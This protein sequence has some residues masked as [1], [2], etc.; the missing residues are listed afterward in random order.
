[1]FARKPLLSWIFAGFVGLSA[2]MP[3]AY[4]ALWPPNATPRTL[5]ELTLLLSEA[6]P[7]LHVI[8]V[9]PN[10]PENGV[11]VCE[12]PRSWEQLSWLRRAPEYSDQWQGV[13]YCERLR[14]HWYILEEDFDS[15]G[16]NALRVGP[17]LF[18]GD[19]ALLRRIHNA[20]LDHQG[21]NDT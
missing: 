15:W 14:E 19:P 21:T 16:E 8:P 13:V 11:W 7:E 20:I 5:T 18:F 3:L 1:M 17:I 9:T 4:R 10:Y 6:E 12:R 2:A